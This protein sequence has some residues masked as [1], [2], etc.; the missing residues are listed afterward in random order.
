MMISNYKIKAKSEILIRAL[1]KNHMTLTT[2]V[3]H[4][5]SD[6]SDKTE[7]DQ[8]IVFS[9]KNMI[10]AEKIIFVLNAAIQIIQLKSANT[11]LI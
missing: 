3:T 6:N 8:K 5:I 2:H 9:S 1:N 7:V 10:I 4:M 11:C